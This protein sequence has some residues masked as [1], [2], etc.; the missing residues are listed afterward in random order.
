[1]HALSANGFV[2]RKKV[3]GEV[4]GWGNGFVLRI[5]KFR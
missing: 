3:F 5:F 4:V 1:M 2:L